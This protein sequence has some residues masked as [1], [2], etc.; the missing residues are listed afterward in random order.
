[1]KHIIEPEDRRYDELLS[2]ILAKV[3]E[4]MTI[5]ERMQLV[6]HPDDVTY[7]EQY[8]LSEGEFAYLEFL[9]GD[10]LP[11]IDAKDRDV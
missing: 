8:R 4:D 2:V 10:D 3:D 7:Y 6:M 1:M 11:A 9:L 5:R